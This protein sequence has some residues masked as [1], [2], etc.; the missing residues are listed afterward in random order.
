MC[1]YTRMARMKVAAEDIVCYKMLKVDRTNNGIR[2]PVAN[3][4]VPYDILNGGIPFYADKSHIHR[5]KLINNN[6]S[7]FY[8]IEKGFIHAWSTE[9]EAKSYVYKFATNACF[10]TYWK[11]VLYKCVIPK[12]TRYYTDIYSEQY[13]S[14]CI[15]FKEKL[16]F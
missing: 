10:N 5:E 3:V 6:K 9:Y 1:L 14:D 13:A 8:E 15:I 2:T 4:K 12:G 11:A 7:I 16:D